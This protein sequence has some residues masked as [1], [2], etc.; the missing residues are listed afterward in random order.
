V[1]YPVDV[2]PGM[3]WRRCHHKNKTVTVVTNRTRIDRDGLVFVGGTLSSACSDQDE[4]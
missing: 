1:L 4:K 3:V 2:V